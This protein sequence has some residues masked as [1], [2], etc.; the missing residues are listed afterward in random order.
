MKK[1]LFTIFSMLSAL[2][3]LIV[4]QPAAEA[5]TMNVTWTLTRDGV[6]VEVSDYIEGGLTDTGGLIRFK[7]QGVYALTASVTDAAG[8]VF[9]QTSTVTVYPAI[10]NYNC[11]FNIQ[12]TNLHISESIDVTMD[13]EVFAGDETIVWS[14]TR[15]GVPVD[16]VGTLNNSGGSINVTATGS[17]ELTATINDG[18]GNEASC[19]RSFTVFNNAP[20]TPIINRAPIKTIYTTNDDITITATASDPD[21]DSVTLVWENRIAQTAKYPQGVRTIRCKAVDQWGAESDWVTVTIDVR[22]HTRSEKI[23]LVAGSPH[24]TIWIGANHP[25]SRITYRFIV[26]PVPGYLGDDVVDIEGF[27]I[28]ESSFERIRRT[29]PTNGTNT[30]GTL[31]HKIYS[32]IRGCYHPAESGFYGNTTIELILT[33]E[34]N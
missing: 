20:N 15:D 32:A 30:T 13:S 2:T 27:N 31:D 8:R 19:S 16:F 1:L 4:F 5:A 24:V 25:A 6:N 17:Y 14:L 18:L 22:P 29:Y 12:S 26:P 34:Y 3:L 11:D 33:F 28:A 23:T 9:T 10:I 21:G 7:Q